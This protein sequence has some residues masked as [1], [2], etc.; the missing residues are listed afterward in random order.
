MKNIVLILALSFI[1][2]A[3]YAS[4]ARLEALGEDQ[5]GSRYIDDERNIF[6]NPAELNNHFDFMALDFG[7]TAQIL[8]GENTA[9]ATGGVINKLGNKVYGVYFGQDSNT[10]AG[11]RIGAFAAL[12]DIDLGGGTKGISDANYS[13]VASR[14]K[15]TNTV[16]LFYAREAAVKWG[17]KLNYSSS[18]DEVGT[19]AVGETSQTGA[20]LSAGVIKGDWEIATTI[21]LANNAEAEDVVT[22]VG[23]ID[24][25]Y[26]GAGGIELNV[27]KR[28]LDGSNYFLQARRIQAEQDG[29]DDL[30]LGTT[31]VDD[32][33]SVLRLVL[34]YGR[35]LKQNE[36]L[37]LFYKGWI[38]ND[39]QTSKAFV[40]D[41]DVTEQYI[42]LLVGME[43]ALKDWLKIRGSVSNKFFGS[44]D[45]DGDKKTIA[46]AV[47]VN[48]G[49][50]L[51]FGDMSIDGII[52]TDADGDGTLGEAGDKGG[53][54]RT[55]SLMSRVS[56]T[57]RF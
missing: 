37:D 54:L 42:G 26:K 24:Y 55:D 47:D 36:S 23:T 51:I 45:V 4:K 14:L 33:W 5:N 11:Q 17:V 1:A 30:T 40:K 34:G 16:D 32:E 20:S 10:A 44:E 19:G 13:A 29:L 31:E 43:S 49:T 27:T 50:S 7:N 38:Y 15:N 52:G 2:S 21:G 41:N 12:N 25:E 18:K 48:I 56:M 6:L 3:A 22:N 9:K 57:Y 8:D 35:V 53:V 46:N 28:N 39:Q